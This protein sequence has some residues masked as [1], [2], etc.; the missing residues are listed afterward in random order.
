MGI[1]VLSQGIKQ[2]GLDV[3]LSPLSDAE[4]ENDQ[5]YISTPLW[6]GQGQ[7]YLLLPFTSSVTILHI[8]WVK[9]MA[10]CDLF[11]SAVLSTRKR[12]MM[13]VH[14]TFSFHMCRNLVCTL[15]TD[16]IT[17]ERNY[18]CSNKTGNVRTA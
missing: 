9:C 6:C 14:E 13:I 15:V 17:T 18:T 10:F 3:N 2:P 8:C 16:T 7:A 5:S 11:V 12:S 4:F 1:T